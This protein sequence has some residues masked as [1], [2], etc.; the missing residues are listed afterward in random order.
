[1][2]TARKPM[3]RFAEVAPDVRLWIQESG[4]TQAP[5]LLLIVGANGSGVTWPTDLITALGRHHQVIVYDH[6]DTGRSSQAFDTHPYA[7]TDLAADAVAVL[8]ALDIG[9]AHVVGLS[10]GSTLAQLLLLDRPDRLLSATMMGARAL[11]TF[12]P[13]PDAPD[14]PGPDPRMFR[15]WQEMAE[16]RDREAEIAWRVKNDR[17]FNGDV[18][19]FDEEEFRQI[20][21]R[22]IDH[23]GSHEFPTTHGR[24]SPDG[25]DRAA[26]LARVSTPTLVI[27]GP[28]DPINP[29]PH[30]RHL[31]S[32]IPTAQLV[33]IPGMGHILNSAILP[34][35]TEAILTHTT[36][37]SG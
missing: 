26:D 13:G 18:L 9:H 10:L 11:G 29:P 12:T 32:L 17:L 37:H 15:I 31:A 27:E 19:P 8:D 21:E 20:E 33:T 4:A 25:L 3:E 24:L 34:T 23:T 2:N 16:P 6:R 30:A 28:E 35:V 36:A 7:V 5:P 22:V 1:M 14:L